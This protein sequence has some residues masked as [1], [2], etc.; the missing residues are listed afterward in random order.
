MPELT[1]PISGGSIS[2]PIVD[3]LFRGSGGAVMQAGSAA[4][5]PRGA[6]GTEIKRSGFARLMNGATP[7][8]ALKP[9]QAVTSRTR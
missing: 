8:E 5:G 2:R 9:G 1:G 4:D 3:T 7:V 6:R